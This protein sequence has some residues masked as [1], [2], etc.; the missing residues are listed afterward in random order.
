MRQE[1]FAFYEFD[2]DDRPLELDRRTKNDLDDA[3]HS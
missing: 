2:F 3:P 1:I